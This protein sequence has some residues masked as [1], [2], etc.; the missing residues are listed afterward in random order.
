MA[1]DD[2]QLTEAQRIAGYQNQRT[3]VQRALRPFTGSPTIPNL[4]DYINRELVPA[5]R[6]TR[7]AVND[8]YLPVVDNAPSANPLQYYFS[9][10]TTNADPTAGFIRLNAATQDTATII[11]VSETNARLV[12]ALPWLDVM[13]GGATAPLGV[14]TLSDATNPARFIRFDLNTMTDVGTYWNLGVTPVESSSDNPFA[15]GGGLV[16]SFIPGVGGATPAT[17]P[18]TSLAAI[19]ANTVLANATGSSA[20]PTAFPL[21][22]STVLGRRATGNIVALTGVQQGEIL[23]RETVVT[24][25]TSSG[26]VATYTIAAATTQVQFKL[27][28]AATIHGMTASSATFGKTIEFS[29]DS[30][31]AGSV[32]FKNESGSAGSALERVRT[33]GGSDFVLKAGETAIATYF[34]SRWR[35]T[36]IGKPVQRRFPGQPIYDVMDAPF[37]AAG[38]GVTDDLT[39]INAAIAA[40]NAVPGT[41][42]FGTNHR[43]SAGLDAITGSCV[44]LQGRGMDSGGTVLTC[45]TAPSAIITIG[46][47]AR[48]S[49]VRD[50][51]VGSSV[52]STSG[53]AIR[54]LSAF[55]CFLENVR[56]LVAGSGV[57]VDRCNTTYIGN[58]DVT[59][60]IG[61]YGF[62][63][64]GVSPDFNHVVRFNRCQV[65]VAFPLGLN[66]GRGAWASGTSYTTG[67]VVRSNGGLWQA[68]TTGTSGATAPG[69]SGLPS[70]SASTVHT[71]TVSDG[72]VSW[73]YAMGAFAGFAHGSYAHT[74][75]YEQCGVLQGDIGMHVFDTAGSPPT[76]M[77]SWQFSADH[78]FRAGIVIEDCDGV[79][80]FEQVLSGSVLSGSAVEIGADAHN[81]QF[82]GGEVG[83]AAQH[84]FLIEG[85]GGK[86]LGVQVSGCSI[87]T[88][89]TYDGISIA[90]G[91]TDIVI[92]GC[93]SGDIPGRAS[94]ARYGISLGAGAD[95]YVVTN[96]ICLGNN[97]GAILNTPGRADTRVVE[98]N[99]PDTEIAVGSVW[100]LQIDHGASDVPRE[101]TK[102]ELGENLRR[103][104]VVV[105]STSSGTSATYTIASTTTQVQFKLAGALTING[106]TAA[107]LTFGKL[108]AFSFDT[109]HAGSVTWNNESGSAGAALE[110]VR[111]PSAVALTISAG[112]TAVF[113][114]FD[115]RWRCIA[116]GKSVTGLTDGDKGDI[117]VSSS[118]TVWTV[119]TNINKT[120]TGVHSFTGA[121][122]TVDVTG[123]ANIS[124]DAASTITTSVGNMTLSTSQAGTRVI[125]S[126]A[127]DVL[128]EAVADDVFINSGGDTQMASTGIFRVNTNG[129]ERLEIETDGAWQVNG[130][131]GTSGLPLI[132]KGNAA[133]PEW[134]QLATA[135]LGDAQVTL[136]K[137]ADL[138]QSRIIG[139]AEG[140]GTGVPTALTPTQVVAIIDGENVTWTGAHSFNGATLSASTSSDIT[141]SAGGTTTLSGGTAVQVTS[142]FNVV[143]SLGLTTVVG[144]SSTG[145]VDNLNIGSVTVVRFTGPPGTLSGMVSAASGQLVMI[146]N[147]HASTAFPILIESTSSSAANRFA[148]TGT[149]RSL[150]AGEMAV[151]WYDSTS[152]RWRLS[153][154]DNNIV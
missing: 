47:G 144:N 50:L 75:L 39:A 113:E 134:E 142:P 89:N 131:T 127:D 24:D 26:T 93:T 87:Q 45:S 25:T 59:D 94:Q 149:S 125:V 129:T 116:V 21:S 79:A 110:R 123:A 124:A 66:Q 140:A 17:V 82:H 138:A 42:Y 97:T 143:S 109:G 77:H 53:Y 85:D 130:N 106:M 92:D 71:T 20:A 101:V 95:N 118:G 147:A 68:A 9:A 67:D 150:A 91:V 58:V 70:S 84:G 128:I 115:S 145:T 90:A 86:I 38:D 12:D 4:L 57:E 63:T 15:S 73:R 98:G 29:F 32:T 81:W 121:S 33:P 52:A 72:A 62:Y 13:S 78:P 83:P 133:S 51:R 5:L 152:S 139:R 37:N 114:Y 112:E 60:V 61:P 40:A 48:M 23:R 119:D 111:T 34:D 19:A 30:G 137:M 7:E 104:T 65:G 80:W 3:G 99:V 154:R 122:H 88:A 151:A 117:T 141:L 56:I 46:T 64:H 28:G 126:G 132:S 120:W 54:M 27:T 43:I 102:F 76:F 69:T 14:V 35:I 41:I 18:P 148:G 74:N 96:N 10:D 107:T 8:V 11:R 16:V 136:A 108:V 22:A 153:I 36:G 135:G 103:E 1:C 49:G 44:V 31:F 100:G 55:R 105:D 2:R 6:Q 146:A